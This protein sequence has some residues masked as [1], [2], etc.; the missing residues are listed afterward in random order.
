M[1][2][3]DAIGASAIDEV[4]RKEGHELVKTIEV[5]DL[6]KG[7]QIGESKK[8]IAYTIEY[9][10]DEKTLKDEDV[11]HVHAKIQESLVKKLGVQIR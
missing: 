6:Y 1:L 2:I 9:R 11:N 3:D 8:S 10:S 7:Q 5:F 4:I